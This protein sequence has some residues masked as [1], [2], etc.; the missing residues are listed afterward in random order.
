V[1]PSL[2][3]LEVN[4][5]DSGEGAPV[6]FLHGFPDRANGWRHQ[7]E[8]LAGSGFRCIAPDLRGFGDTE[9][10]AAV[11][12]YAVPEIERDLLALL[13]SLDLERVQLVA[14][15]WGA[16]FGW[17]FAAVHPDRVERFA[18]LQI[19]HPNAFF[20]AAEEARRRSWYLLF[21]LAEG[22]AEEGL[23]EDDW[24]LFREWSGDYPDVEGAIADLER[25]GRLTAALNWY[26]ANVTADFYRR[27]AAAPLPSVACP[28]MGIWS[29]GEKFVTED[30]MLATKDHVD[31]PWRYERIEDAGHWVHLEAPDQVSAL[32]LDFLEPAS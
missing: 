12:A 31:G 6:V 26:R 16:S 21:F 13:D 15:D 32:L 23:R 17:Y 20:A 4:L 2:N 19:G 30:Q 10:P 28:T 18:A 1:S 29:G 22:T 3:E 24:R 11:E 7:I 25:P 27:G 8:A 14:T 5:I 9:A